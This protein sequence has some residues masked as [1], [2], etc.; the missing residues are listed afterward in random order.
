MREL[1]SIDNPFGGQVWHVGE[2]SSTMDETANLMA[3]NPGADFHGSMVVADYQSQGRGRFA[4]RIWKGRAGDSLMFTIMLKPVPGVPLSLT[5]ALGICY[6]LENRGLAPTVKWP[7]DILVGE[8][9]ICGILVT[10]TTRLMHCGVGLNLGS[11]NFQADT[12]KRSATSLAD[13]GMHLAPIPALA[14]LLPCLYMV[15]SQ[16][17]DQQHSEL[18]K[19]LWKL[20]QSVEILSGGPSGTP[21]SGLVRGLAADGALV[22]EGQAGIQHI[23]SGE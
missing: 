5:L 6:F 15:L 13:Q 1:L 12:G 19:R 18:Q 2:T 22:L 11:P 4:N 9:K 21:V 10:G 8:Q 17:T 23:Y 7:N 3:E 16:T 14:E 20:N